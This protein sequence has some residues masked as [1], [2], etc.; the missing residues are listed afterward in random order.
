MAEVTRTETT[1]QYNL[2][3]SQAIFQLLEEDNESAKGGIDY[4][5]TEDERM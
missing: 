2:G 4:S 3:L 1:R 5:D